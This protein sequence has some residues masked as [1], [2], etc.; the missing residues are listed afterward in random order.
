MD[1]ET[2]LFFVSR[3]ALG[4]CAS[5]SLPVA[6]VC[7]RGDFER[8]ELLAAIG[9]SALVHRWRLSID[10]TTDRVLYEKTD[11]S[12]T[13]PPVT[14]PHASAKPRSV[15]VAPAAPQVIDP[16]ATATKAREFQDSELKAGREIS[17]S[18]AVAHVLGKRG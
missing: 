18:Q 7:L 13:Q 10:K 16:V 3:Q 8:H 5:F 2:I 12:I 6:E 4:E 14:L 9:G 1:S 17:A 11:R 15:P